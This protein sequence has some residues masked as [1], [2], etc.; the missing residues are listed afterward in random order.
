MG[1]SYGGPSSSRRWHGRRSFDGLLSCIF[2]GALLLLIASVVCVVAMPSSS[3]A[4][5]N[6]S[7]REIGAKA[8]AR[9]QDGMVQVIQTAENT[10]ERWANNGYITFL[11]DSS[12]GNSYSVISVDTTQTFQAIEGFGAAFTDSV[13]YVFWKLD[14]KTQQQILDS[15]F[16]PA[17]L[18]YTLCRLTINSCDFSV[19][20]YSYDDTPNDYNLTA[21]SIAHDQEQIIPLIKLAQNATGNYLRFFSTPW[22]P[23]AWMKSNNAMRN[24]KMPGLIQDPLIFES[25]ALYFSKY[26]SAYEAEGV[27]IWGITIQNEPH[28]ADQFP[29]IGDY[30]CCG[31][32]STN[33][34]EFLKNYLGPRLRADH[35]GVKIMIHDD[36]KEMLVDFVTDI[37]SDPEAAQY[38]WGAAYHWYGDFLKNYQYLAQLHDM[39]PNL[40]T[41][42]T[43]ATLEAYWK[44]TDKWLQ[45]QYYAIDII[46][47]LNNWAMGWIDWNFLLDVDGGPQHSLGP[48]DAPIRA[49]YDTQ[50][51]YY[52]DQYWHFGHFSRYLPQGSLRVLS[53]LQNATIAPPPEPLQFTSFV[54]SV[55][56]SVVVIVLNLNNID[57]TY[58]LFDVKGGR[59][60]EITIPA[61]GIQTLIY[62]NA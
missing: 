25:W 17:G 47:D 15:F 60:A 2:V 50:E 55:D 27:D 62:P 40:P 10:G 35:P 16:G 12:P 28:V 18:N 41:L 44:Q 7:I 42:A 4:S 48:C 52:G 43:E 33:E 8:I 19:G 31:F 14:E 22:S 5:L 37:M 24:S 53:Q 61:N 26:I 13:A 46:G 3:T 11:N 29:F 30:E 36:Q 45:G 51:L 59:V 1:S 32:N 20:S 38:V 56:D 6:A 9:P 49:N 34:K 58:E 39:Y 54:S 23:P 57:L 21:F